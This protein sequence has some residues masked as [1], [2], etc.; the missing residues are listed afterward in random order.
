MRKLLYSFLVLAAFS[1]K[2]EGAKLSLNQKTAFTSTVKA[3][4]DSVGL[5]PANDNDSVLTL[6]WPAVNYSA[7]LAVTYTLELDVPGDTSGTTPWGK[8]QK[9][10]ENRPRA[11]EE[12]FAFA[13]S[14]VAFCRTGEITYAP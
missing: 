5:A 9:F 13:G 4:L 7:S 6:F 10:V 1:C 8:A 2:K 14:Q 12:I 3:S 11:D